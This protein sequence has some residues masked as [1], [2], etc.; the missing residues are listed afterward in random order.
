MHFF[1][2]EGHKVLKNKKGR[3]KNKVDVPKTLNRDKQVRAL[4]P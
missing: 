2:E 3:G 1:F 4:V